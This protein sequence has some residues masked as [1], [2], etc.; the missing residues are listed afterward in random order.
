[1]MFYAVRDVLPF[2]YSVPYHIEESSFADEVLTLLF[3]FAVIFN[4]RPFDYHLIEPAL[5]RP[6]KT[7]CSMNVR[8]WFSRPLFRNLV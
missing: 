2:F 6:I 8:N 5:P 1:M 7:N 4:I 3:Y